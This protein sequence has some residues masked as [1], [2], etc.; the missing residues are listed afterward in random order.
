MLSFAT[1][2][3]IR[4]SK[5]EK[6]QE[7]KSKYGFE[8]IDTFIIS[9]ALGFINNKKDIPSKDSAVTAN[10]PRTVLN[11]HS[12]QIDDICEY[13]V[14][15][16]DLEANE[17]LAIKVAFEDSSLENA[18]KLEKLERFIDYS[19]GGIEILYEELTSDKYA[20]SIDGMKNL[21]DKYISSANIQV[22]TPE[23]IF[24]ELGI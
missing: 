3:V 4:G 12:S 10:I 11:S 21:L 8:L 18:S 6:Y 17:D 9:A 20:D 7:L 22:K 2:I 23:E 24:K 5:A 1:D 13:I 19:Y 16:E 14:L 15:S